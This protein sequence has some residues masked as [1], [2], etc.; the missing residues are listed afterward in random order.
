LLPSKFVYLAET[1]SDLADERD[2][3]LDELQQR[4][5][6]VLPEQKL[7]LEEAKKTESTIRAALAGCALS[8]SHDRNTLRIDARR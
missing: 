2:L 4:G 7:P 5:Y 1:T 6:G 8:V 3:V